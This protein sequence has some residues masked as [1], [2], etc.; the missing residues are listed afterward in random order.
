MVTDKD[1]IASMLVKWAASSTLAALVPAATV[2]ADRIAE[3]V[4]AEAGTAAAYIRVDEGEINRFGDTL[5]WRKFD[6]EVG[7][8]CISSD[9][10][11]ESIRS[12][13]VGAFGGNSTDWTAGLTLTGANVMHCIQKDDGGIK[14][15]PGVRLNGSDVLAVTTFF[16]VMVNGAS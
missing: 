13:V 1:I 2:F 14:P 5:Y 16:E 8:S 7:V 3:G 6:V 12:A 4:G 11:S 10:T 9:G 15:K